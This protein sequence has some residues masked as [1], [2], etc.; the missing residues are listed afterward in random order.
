MRLNVGWHNA[1]VHLTQQSETERDFLTIAKYSTVLGSI[2]R[3]K[4]G[5]NEVNSL[6]SDILVSDEFD[7]TMQK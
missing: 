3:A 1:G 5:H 2:P 4:S 7:V 6:R